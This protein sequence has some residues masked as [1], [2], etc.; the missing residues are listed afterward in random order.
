MKGNFQK[1][2]FMVGELS[3]IR[4]QFSWRKVITLKYAK[5]LWNILKNMKVV[6]NLESNKIFKFKEIWSR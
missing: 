4:I 2:I 5:I 1:D 6:I 3:T